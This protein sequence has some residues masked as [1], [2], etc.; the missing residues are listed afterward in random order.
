MTT[1]LVQFPWWLAGWS[2]YISP[3]SLGRAA[4]CIRSEAMPHVQSSSPAAARGTIAHKFLADVLEHGV[5]EA[6]NLVADPADIDWLTWIQIDK[7]PAFDPA[8][9]APEVALAYNPRTRTAR[10]LGRNISREQARALARDEEIVGIIDVLGATEDRAI[11]HDYKTGHGYVEPAEENWQ[12]RAYALFAARWLGRTGAVYSVIRAKDNGETP[13]TDAAALDEYDLMVFEDELIALLRRRDGV[14]TLTREGRWNELPPLVEGRHCRYCPAFAFCPA[15]TA[16]VKALAGEADKP[17]ELTPDSAALAWKRL[18]LAQKALERYESILRDYARQQPL[19][20]GE[21]EVLGL[22]LKVTESIV[23]ARL[24]DVAERQWGPLG[25]AL[26]GETIA[27][28]ETAT[29]ARFERALKKLI[30][31]TL[32]EADQKITWLKRDAYRLLREN[33]ALSVETSHT[34][35]EHVP[36]PPKA[37]PAGEDTEA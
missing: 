16:G 22:K 19:P 33:R 11:V 17:G 37:L 36:A 31:P 2:R 21:G 30:L 29:K 18:R 15:K 6:L 4:A 34:V 3:S 1:D 9:Y 25:A 12:L 35:C 5:E 27:T 20:L 23:P 8:A 28:E 10:E 24:R 32:P 14:R 26:A 13:W 7:L